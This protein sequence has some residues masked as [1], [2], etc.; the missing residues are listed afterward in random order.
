MK[1]LF[2]TNEIKEEEKEDGKNPH[3]E[4]KAIIKQFL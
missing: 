4:R 3:I 2:H 1:N